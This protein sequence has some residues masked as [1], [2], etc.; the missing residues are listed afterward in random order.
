MSKFSIHVFVFR[1]SNI[2]ATFLVDKKKVQLLKERLIVL[3]LI[4]ERKVFFNGE[5][6]VLLLSMFILDS[7]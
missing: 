4:F 5:K 6:M 2:L 1:P 3:V 7:F